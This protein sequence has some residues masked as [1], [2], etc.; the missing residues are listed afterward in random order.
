M[1]DYDYGSD[2]DFS[3]LERNFGV[4]GRDDNSS[5]SHDSYFIVGRPDLDDYDPEYHPNGRD[6]DDYD[7]EYQHPAFVDF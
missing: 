1:S 7:S 6:H 2:D 4:A 5:S 3:D